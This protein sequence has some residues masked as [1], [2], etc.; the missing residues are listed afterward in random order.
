MKYFLFTL[1]FVLGSLAVSGQSSDRHAH[2]D[3]QSEKNNQLRG[4]GKM[5]SVLGD[6]E[7]YKLA[8]PE[9]GIYKI[10]GAFLQNEMSVSLGSVNVDRI[11]VFGNKGGRIPEAIRVPRTEDLEEIPTMAIGLRD[12]QFDPQDQLIFYAEGSGSWVENEGQWSFQ[13]NIYDDFNYIFIKLNGEAR[14]SV[15]TLPSEELEGLKSSYTEH[16][17]YGRDALNLLG[18][19]I[20]HQ[21]SG[22]TWLSDEISNT[23]S[24]D[25]TDEFNTDG[26]V[27]GSGVWIQSDFYGR[28]ENRSTYSVTIGSEVFTKSMGGIEYDPES[29]YA[30]LGSVSQVFE[31][32]NDL[33]PIRIDYPQ[34]GVPS[35]GWVD[36]VN[37][38]F[39]K[40][41]SA[42]RQGDFLRD[43]FSTMIGGFDLPDIAGMV[44][45]EVT[46]IHDVYAIES[47]RQNGRM[48]FS[49][50]GPDRRE[51]CVFDPEAVIAE[52]EFVSRLENQ[53]L[54][55]LT[56]IEMV[57]LTPKAFIEEAMRLSEHRSNYSGLKVEVVDVAKVY[58]EFSSGR[59]DPAAI[60]DF[61]K[62]LYDEAN[63]F[64]YLLL[65]GDGSYDWKYQVKSVRNENFIPVYETEESM[66]PI[67]AYPSDDFY[68]L[69]DDDEGED[70]IG[71]LDLAVGRL[72]ARTPDEAR[73]LVDKIVRY[74]SDP[75]AMGD[76]RNR[77]IY[78]AD[79][80]DGNRHI[81]DIDRI[82]VDISERYPAYNLDKIYFDAYEQVATPGGARYPDAKAAINTAV[83]KGGLVMTYLGHGGP[84]G[85][86]Q[87][88]VLQ[89]TD[90]R[91]WNNLNN[92]P[93]IITAT[94]SFTGFDNP[95]I[96]T[97]GEYSVLNPNGG[98]IAILSTVRAVYAQDNF[99]LTNSVHD[100]L[101]ETDNGKPIP[102]GEVM[103]LAKN[104]IK[105]GADNS[106]N[107]K[108]SLFGDPSMTL[109]IPRYKVV[110]E[111][112]NGQPASD[113]KDTLGAL[114]SVT[115]SG[116]VADV[117]LQPLSDFNG[118]I[119]P[120]VFDKSLTLKTKGQDRRSRVKMFEL[121]KNTIFKGA[122]N[123]E[124]GRFKFTFVV[125]KD[126][127][128]DIG[129]GKISY[130]ASDLQSRDANGDYD[131]LTIGGVGQDTLQ[132]DEP[133]LVRVFM[134]DSNFVFGGIT[135]PDPVL[136]LELEDD[137][138]IN[139][140]GNSIG[141]DLKA[142]LDNNS[143]QSFILN[144]FYESEVNNYKKGTVRYPLSDLEPGR[145]S[146]AVTVWDI[147]NNFSEGYT[148][149]IVEDDPR[150]V[151]KHIFNFPNPFMDRT[152]FSFEHTL[153]PGDMTVRIEIFSVSGKHVKTIEHETFSNGFRVDEIEWDG[154]DQ[155]G[156]PIAKGVYLYKINV[157]VDVSGTEFR[158][159]SDFERLVVLK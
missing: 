159:E 68:G 136:Y 106:N 115:V 24:I 25:L 71:D 117:D 92:M 22:Q 48:Q 148:E 28:S 44:V 39:R 62:K 111:T 125:P 42:I 7:I 6:G 158:K 94:C 95:E 52:P 80:E 75:S 144:D 14:K 69:L 33:T 36:F 49:T 59:Q 29:T 105:S 118:I 143:Q 11:Q 137:N 84:T 153:P 146:I 4:G 41:T 53:N 74:D 128:F 76:W 152:R 101:Y 127:N 77:Q 47:V 64:K 131:G 67:Y 150:G 13:T 110:T 5:E 139:V 123:V 98:A 120:T 112:I 66:A 12:G 58:N 119:Y 15:P 141:H 26:L 149:F 3:W 32:E 157:Q 30:R 60:R 51:F 151:L 102:I 46:D 134:N 1:T 27:A 132:D 73:T 113:F 93:I 138:G 83:F 38:N 96:T 114:Q 88:R 82:A 86:A 154:T 103:R 126:I 10:T 19:S 20:S 147:A 122:S 78:L 129:S 133:P 54:H 91:S 34:L 140:V 116:Y 56:D 109:A 130:Y 156:S 107:R 104:N 121:Q 17:Y 18:R 50:I 100:Y 124:E 23:R 57:I 45:W 87:E 89:T 81:D 9:K 108:F 63:S 40:E 142:V 61:C 2:I 21:G 37:I 85:L 99:V 97:A 55:G 31:A 145:H 79:D 70:L 35:E 72:L 8:V 43:T 16:Q 65:F 155:T 90:I 135:T